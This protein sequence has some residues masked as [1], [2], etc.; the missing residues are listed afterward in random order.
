MNTFDAIKYRRTIDPDNYNG[1][2]TPKE[3]I[4]KMLEA[5]NWAPTHGLTEPWRFII[6][7]KDKVHN[8]GELHAEVYRQNTPEEQFLQKK[9]DKLKYRAQH[10]SH[11]IICVNRKGN[12]SNIPEIEEI[13]ATSCAI[14]NMLLVATQYNTA[15]FWS[16]GGMCY[17][18]A[19]KQALGLEE[20]DKILGF[21]YVGQYDIPHPDGKRTTDWKE[22]ASWK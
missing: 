13:A 9:N 14:Q 20:T 10:C 16:T 4:E 22:K 2:D 17:H 11:V 8:L 18:P 15:T 6:Y 21:I 5:A 3:I 12:K 19:L 1:N 7:A